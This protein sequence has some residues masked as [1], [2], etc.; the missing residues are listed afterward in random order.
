MG[1]REDGLIG[2]RAHDGRGGSVLR[3]ALAH[4]YECGE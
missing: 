3:H 1:D 2:L 4:S